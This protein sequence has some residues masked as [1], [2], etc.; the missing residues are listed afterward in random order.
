M[1]AKEEPLGD[2]GG[3]TT[4]VG[5]DKRK[6]HASDK[7]E[8]PNNLAWLDMPAPLAQLDLRPAGLND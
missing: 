5:G 2:F 3:S 4:G 1:A 8:G 7:A 6:A